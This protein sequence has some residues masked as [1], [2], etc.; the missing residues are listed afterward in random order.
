MVKEI[1]LPPPG[2]RGI[3]ITEISE[4]AATLIRDY[5]ELMLLPA[6]EVV[7]PKVHSYMDPGLRSKRA[8]MELA[9]RM[10]QA[11]MLDTVHVCKGQGRC[12]PS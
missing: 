1:S 7:E 3:P 8:M 4:R 5:K 2:T 10:A 11:D 9:V 6:E 12:S